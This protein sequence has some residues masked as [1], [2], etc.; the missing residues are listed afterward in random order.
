MIRVTPGDDIYIRSV[1][2]KKSDGT[3]QEHSLKHLFP[4][5]LSTISHSHRTAEPPEELSDSIVGVSSSMRRL[6][7]TP[8]R[9]SDCNEDYLWF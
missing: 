8:K 4:L 2:I 7:R 6:R 3:T 5:E 1:L 9:V